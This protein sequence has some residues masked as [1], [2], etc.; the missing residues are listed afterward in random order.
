[1]KYRIRKPNIKKIPDKVRQGFYFETNNILFPGQLFNYCHQ[2]IY[3]FVSVIE[4]Q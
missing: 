4:S 2:A 3:L 1:L